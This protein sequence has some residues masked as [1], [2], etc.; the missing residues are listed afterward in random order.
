[1]QL[2]RSLPWA[3]VGNDFQAALLLDFAIDLEWQI[4]LSG[5]VGSDAFPA[6]SVDVDGQQLAAGVSVSAFFNQVEL[7]IAAGSFRTYAIPPYQRIMRIES[8][9]GGPN[10][11]LLTFYPNARPEWR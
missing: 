3:V 2:V 6:R 5:N 7:N 1:M 10:I 4:T 8:S 9:A 11:C